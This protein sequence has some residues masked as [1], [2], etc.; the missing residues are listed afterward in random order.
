MLVIVF[1]KQNSGQTQ[2][3][4]IF[5]LSSIKNAT[6]SHSSHY[7][8]QDGYKN[9]PVIFQENSEKS[10]QIVSIHSNVEFIFSDDRNSFLKLFMKR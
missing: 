2:A 10:I 3:R 6:H 1:H 8:N 4:S 7:I 5:P 9:R